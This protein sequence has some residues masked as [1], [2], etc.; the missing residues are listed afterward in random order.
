MTSDL[1]YRKFQIYQAFLRF[2]GAK[3]VDGILGDLGFF[4]I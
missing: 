3:S 4:S 1:F 2:Y